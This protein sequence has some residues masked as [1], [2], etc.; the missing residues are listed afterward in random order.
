MSEGGPAL[1]AES[2]YDDE[3]SGRGVVRIAAVAALGGLLFG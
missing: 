2:I 1:D 3:G